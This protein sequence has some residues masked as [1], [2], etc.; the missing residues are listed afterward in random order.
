MSELGYDALADPVDD[1]PL[2]RRMAASSS[3][4]RDPLPRPPLTQRHA[5][6]STSPQI[7]ALLLDQSFAA[8][9]GNWVGDEVLYQARVHPATRSRDLREATGKLV[10]DTLRQVVHAAVSANADADRFPRHWLFHYR[11]AKGKGA[12]K[13]VAGRPIIF[14]TVGGRTSAVVP[15]LQGATPA[16]SL[17]NVASRS[18]HNSPQADGADKAGNKESG[19]NAGCTGAAETGRGARKRS[20]AAPLDRTDAIAPRRSR[21][22]QQQ[23]QSSSVGNNL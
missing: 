20:R 11:W 6:D 2:L 23:R 14:V 15:A 16:A 18:E 9:V 8:G 5:S 4:V 17:K 19:D 3:P 1:A 13:D 12:Q 7:K 22:R 10:L 21:R